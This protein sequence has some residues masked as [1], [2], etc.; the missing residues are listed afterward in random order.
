[1]ASNSSSDAGSRQSAM[2]VMVSTTTLPMIAAPARE[3]G[4]AL[5]QPDRRGVAEAGDDAHRAQ[6]DRQR[7]D[8][9]K[10]DAA[11][12]RRLAWHRRYLSVRA[13]T[14]RWISLVPS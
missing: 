3:D 1:M 9:G 6:A 12:S 14:R 4:D 13:I 2:W 5:E 7:R 10:E 8:G 11:Q